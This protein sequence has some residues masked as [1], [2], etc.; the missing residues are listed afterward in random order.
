MPV[1]FVV[2]RVDLV[3]CP[4]F[5]RFEIEVPRG[6]L[7]EIAYK[8]AGGHETC[9]YHVGDGASQESFER[10][11]GTKS[12][13]VVPSEKLASEEGAGIVQSH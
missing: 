7:P 3:A 9:L 4:I 5:E 1:H 8:D 2:H 12:D 11:V 10:L 13:Q 6:T